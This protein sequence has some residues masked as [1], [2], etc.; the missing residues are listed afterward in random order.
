MS[1]NVLPTH[2]ID[3]YQELEHLDPSLSPLSSI[4]SEIL[5]A[6]PATILDKPI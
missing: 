1:T 5:E 6:A 2:N 4:S 3:I